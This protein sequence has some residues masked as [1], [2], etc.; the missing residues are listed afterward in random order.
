M[1]FGKEVLHKK[2]SNKHKLS[3]NWLNGI[4]TILKRYKW[5]SDP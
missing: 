3:E 5:I 4:H 2:F 1:K